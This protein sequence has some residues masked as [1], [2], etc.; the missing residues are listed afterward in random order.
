MKKLAKKLSLITAILMVFQLASFGLGVGTQGALAAVDSVSPTLVMSPAS[1][2]GTTGEVTTIETTVY[3]DVL[4]ASAEISFDGGTTFLSMTETTA[5]ITAA[6]PSKKMYIYSKPVPNNSIASII[7]QVRGSDSSGNVTTINDTIT[8]SDNDAPTITQ[9]NNETFKKGP[10][11]P[12]ERLVTGTDNVQIDNLC[13]ELSSIKEGSILA[14][15]VAP[16]SVSRIAEWNVV[17]IFT[18]ATG[19]TDLNSVPNDVYTNNYRVLNAAGNQS[20]TD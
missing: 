5:S 18:N 16:V 2:L 14:T 11:L 20:I 4:V 1:S 17:D 6:D 10:N 3:D 7:Y 12:G 8:V 15:C 13:Y 9:L 19:Y